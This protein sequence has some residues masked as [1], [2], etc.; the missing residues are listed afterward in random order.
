MSRTIS[1]QQKDAR[2]ISR[3]HPWVYR[4]ALS[5]RGEGAK[6]GSVVDVQSREGRFVARGIFDPKGSIAARIWTAD[7]D[8]PI[9]HELLVRRFGQAAALREAAGV[10]GR[11]NAHR[12]V[13]AEGDRMPGVVVDRYADWLTLTLQTPAL[14]PWIGRLAAALEQAV[15]ATGLYLLDDYRS[16]LLRGEPAPEGLTIEEPTV[17]LEVDLATPGKAGVFM[18]MREVRVRLAPLLAGRRFLNLFAHTGAFSAMAARAGAAEV[19]S[20]DLS[21]PYLR[22]AARNV[23]LSAPGYDAHETLSRDVFEALTGLHRE[24]RRF[25][26]VLID[27]PTFSASKQSGAFSVKDGYRPVVRAALRVLDPGGLLVAANN[28]RGITREQ[29]LRLLHDAAH[30]EEVDL[31]VLENHGQPADYPVVPILPE[32]AYLDVALCVVV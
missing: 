6:A 26:A 22:V 12:L 3:G 2:A 28:W 14:E 21:G 25:D 16:K 31:R 5:R 1:L 27:P 7:P 10:P 13:N 24:R 11:S 20:V 19:V 15:P 29:F 23:E 18:D 17:R 8:E 30:Q 32:T 9:D 4:Q